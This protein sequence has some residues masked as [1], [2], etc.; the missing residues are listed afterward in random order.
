VLCDNLNK[1][2]GK[3]MKLNKIALSIAL[4]NL[5]SNANALYVSD[6][7]ARD[8]DIPFYGVVGHVGLAS[9]YEIYAPA[10]FV[11]E[12]INDPK[13]I[14][15]NSLGSFMSAPHKYWGDKQ[16]FNHKSYRTYT[17]ANTIVRQYYACPSYTLKASWVVGELKQGSTIPISCG[18]W[19]CDTLVNYAYHI[20]GYSLPNYGSWATLP[21]DTWV[22]ARYQP[23]LK[24]Q[25]ENQNTDNFSDI[26]KEFIKYKN[27][28]PSH[29][30][31]KYWYD[32]ELA[33][34]ENKRIIY[35]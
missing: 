1:N 22:N 6:L 30:I 20:A 33:D 25:S 34:L 32:A 8:L 28:P 7:M 13:A 31:K 21:M 35:N 14:Q 24:P 10:T 23:N 15:Q 19:R 4:A 29:V 17:T 27:F 16:I 12:A 5:V 18:M 9:A 26:T 2:K 3:K 11:L